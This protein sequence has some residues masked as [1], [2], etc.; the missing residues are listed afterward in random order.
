MT[1]LFIM[2]NNTCSDGGC[3]FVWGSGTPQY[4]NCPES[5][6]KPHADKKKNSCL[7]GVYYFEIP[8]P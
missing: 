2:G 5:V 3:L 7:G 4:G 8:S 6:K 1:L